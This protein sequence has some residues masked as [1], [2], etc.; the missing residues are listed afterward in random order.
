VS[1]VRAWQR[2]LRA[3]RF[4]EARA[5]DPTKNAAHGS[6][7]ISAQTTNDLTRRALRG[8]YNQL[9]DMRTE[10]GGRLTVKKL[11]LHHVASES[12]FPAKAQKKSGAG[13][14]R[15]RPVVIAGQ[16]SVYG[17]GRH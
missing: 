15:R 9:D 16:R 7:R 5:P 11:R 8:F 6:S 12:N 13:I 4:G 1:A 2:Y 14:G 17:T 3:G 10:H